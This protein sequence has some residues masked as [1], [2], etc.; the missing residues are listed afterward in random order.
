MQT[1][2]HH[3]QGSIAST[4]AHSRRQLRLGVVCAAKQQQ[5][6]QKAGSK[7]EYGANW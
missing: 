2:S 5:K 6:Q 7:V 1:L 3:Q 4:Q